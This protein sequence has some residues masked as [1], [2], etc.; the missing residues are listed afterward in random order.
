MMTQH[1]AGMFI[2][3]TGG[4]GNKMRLG[5]VSVHGVALRRPGQREAPGKERPLTGLLMCMFRMHC[6]V[7]G[8][9]SATPHGEAWARR[10]SSTMNASGETTLPQGHGICEPWTHLWSQQGVR[11][12]AWH[13][14][15]TVS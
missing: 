9:G 3:H 4:G 8:R 10:D 5:D 14:K 13:V 1:D 7:E 2:Y 11:Q 6:V 12:E 15:K